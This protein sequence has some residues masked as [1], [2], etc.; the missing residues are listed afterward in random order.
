M[1]ALTPTGSLKWRTSTAGNV[2]IYPGAAAVDQNGAVYFG[3]SDNRLFCYSASGQLVWRLDSG[4]NSAGPALTGDGALCF[5]DGRQTVS[6]LR[7]S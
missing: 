2:G 1:H 3:T 7:Q 6:M 5:S 4:A